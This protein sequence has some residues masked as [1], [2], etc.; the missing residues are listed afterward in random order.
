MATLSSPDSD[1]PLGIGRKLGMHHHCPHIV[2]SGSGSNNNNNN[3][4]NTV[5]NYQHDPL[6]HR[7]VEEN[8]ETFLETFKHKTWCVDSS[9]GGLLDRRPSSDSGDSSTGWTSSILSTTDDLST[10]SPERDGDLPPGAV[11]STA[12]WIDRE[13]IIAESRRIARWAWR[14]ARFAGSQETPCACSYHPPRKLI[15]G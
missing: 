13:G 10:D 2:I 6:A 15:I 4:N 1:D 7:H 8:I 5:K 3:N 14:Q 12:S 9:K 11:G